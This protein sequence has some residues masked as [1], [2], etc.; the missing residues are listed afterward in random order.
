M[1]ISNDTPRADDRWYGVN[2]NNDTILRQVYASFRNEYVPFLTELSKA[3]K[4]GEVSNDIDDII[5]MVRDVMKKILEIIT[6][7]KVGKK[8]A[9]VLYQSIKDIE[10]NKS[11]LMTRVINDEEF[12]SKVEEIYETTGISAK[13]L[14]ITKEMLKAGV[15]QVKGKQVDNEFQSGFEQSHRKSYGGLKSVAEGM[16]VAGL[17]PFAPVLDIVGDVESWLRSKL[18]KPKEK[19]GQSMPGLS[20]GGS[21]SRDRGFQQQT[22]PAPQPVE[23]VSPGINYTEDE[24][25]SLFHFFNTRAYKAKWTKELLDRMKGKEGREPSSGGKYLEYALL[26][27]AVV[28]AIKKWW[29][30]VQSKGKTAAQVGS[31]SV[32]EAAAAKEHQA[33]KTGYAQ[34]IGLKNYADL[35]HTTPERVITEL[36]KTDEALQR[37]V[38]SAERDKL[39]WVGKVRGMRW[40]SDK[41]RNV[42]DWAASGKV[43]MGKAIPKEQRRKDYERKFDY[44]P[45]QVDTKELDRIVKAAA[46]EMKRMGKSVDKLSD[47][48][49]KTQTEVKPVSVGNPFDSAD[50]WVT[51]L[52]AGKLTVGGR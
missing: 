42:V 30:Y 25:K 35:A 46:E 18:I 41:V 1:R 20:M 37:K 21:P 11:R 10:A 14:G 52:S 47:N 6:L 7:G 49:S 39:G 16:K 22:V 13:D 48:V 8:D 9:S 5:L 2:A 33:V 34:K 24:S 15:K 32:S 51:Q 28:Y 23:R 50:P 45:T 43:G 19:R 44:K 4:V 36:V 27:A 31:R 29:D 17:G 3:Y 12:R 38:L 40:V 26:A